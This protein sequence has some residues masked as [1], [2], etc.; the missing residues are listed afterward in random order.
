M[1]DESRT[2][3]LSRA[4]LFGSMCAVAGAIGGYYMTDRAAYKAGLE[5][6]YS[7]FTEQTGEVDLS[8]IVFAEIA[9]GKRA[10]TDEDISQLQERL[11]KAA[12]TADNL[13]RRLNDQQIY[14]TFRQAGVDLK[15]ASDKATDPL[16]SRQLLVAVEQYKFAENE[17][18]ERVIKQQRSLFF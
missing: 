15:I 9:R 18:R 14:K 17:L 4:A 6:N 11:L 7:T 10:R 12:K 3:K 13:A 1:S 16:N 2:G 8:L 5:A